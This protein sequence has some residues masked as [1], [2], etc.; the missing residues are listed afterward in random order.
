MAV[1]SFL[2]LQTEDDESPWLAQQSNQ[3]VTKKGKSV[4]NSCGTGGDSPLMLK[5]VLLPNLRL[6]IHNSHD[7]ALRENADPRACWLVSCKIYLVV[8]VLLA[9]LACLID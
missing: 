9:C 8:S 1:S 5:I 3:V 2:L 7:K 4:E 6:N